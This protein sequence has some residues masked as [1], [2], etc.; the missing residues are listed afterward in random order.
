MSNEKEQRDFTVEEI[1]YHIKQ[2]SAKDSENATMEYNRVFS[3]ALNSGALLREKLEQHMRNQDLWNDAK[4]KE[5]DDLIGDLNQSE[6]KLKK[7]A[8]KL[9]E[10]RNIALDMRRTRVQLQELVAERNRADVNTAQGQAENAR[11][12]YLLTCCLVYK[13]SDKVVYPTVEEYLEKQADGTDAVGLIAAEKFGNLYFGLANDYE[14]GL[15]ENQFL[16]KWQFVDD[17]LRLV[18]KQGQW[19]DTDGKLIDEFGRYVNEDGKF[20][21][22]D[23]NPLTEAGDYDFDTEPFLDDDG[24]PLEEPGEKKKKGRPKKKVVEA[25]TEKVEESTEELEPVAS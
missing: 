8:I 7:G 14:K 25:T 20:I 21:D 5:Y 13:D 24:N 10:A 1:S 11:F 22:A 17:E 18:N 2:P 3:K 23:G 9:S 12:N 4:Q 15:P 16:K 19:V 6:M